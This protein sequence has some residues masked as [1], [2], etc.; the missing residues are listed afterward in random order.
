MLSPVKFIKKKENK[1]NLKQIINATTSGSSANNKWNLLNKKFPYLYP[2]IEDPNFALKISE[3]KE[4]NDTKYD[5]Q[6]YDVTKE[7]QKICNKKFELSAHQQF[8]KNFLSIET[9]YNSLLLYHG[10]GSG[11]TCTA[12]GVAEE[13]RN[14]MKQIGTLKKII[15]VASPNVQENFKLQLFDPSKLELIDGIWNIKNCVGDIFLNE[16]NPM[17][18]KNISK[19]KIVNDI[20]KIINNYYLFYGY[21]EFANT[22]IKDSN[23]DSNITNN[24]EK[25]LKKKL[26][27]IYSGRLIIIDEVHNIRISDDNKDKRVA[28]QLF[29][30]VS[31]VDSL[32][33]LLLSATPL[34][35]TYKEI[36]WLMNIMNI[37]DK[38]SI[39][40]I[41]DVF[42]K[43]GNLKVD[44]NGK[45]IGKEL[46]QEKLTGYVSYVRGDNPYSF[47]Y[48][49]WPYEFDNSKNINLNNYPTMQ[50]NGKMIKKGI[51]HLSLYMSNI[52]EYQQ[53]G[54]NLLLNKIKMNENFE[55]ELEKVDET[56]TLGY[57]QLQKPIEALNIVYPN[58]VIDNLIAYGEERD[59][60]ENNEFVGKSGLNNIMKFR[61]TF[62]PPSKTDFEYKDLDSYGRI[63]S[64]ENIGKYSSKIENICKNIINSDGIILIYSQYLDGGL[65]PVALALEEMGFTR[66]GETPSLFKVKP[67]ENLDLV[68]YTNT[69]G[70]KSIP[71]KYTMIVGDVRLTL[72][73]YKKSDMQALTSNKNK[74]GEIIKVVLI[75]QSGSEGIDFKNIRQVHVLEPWYNLSRIE[76]IIGR[77]VRNCSHKELEFIKRNVQIFLH[78]TELEDENE[79][80]ADLYIYRNAEIK[81]IK[82]GIVNRLLKEI[83]IDCILNK[84]QLNFTK[85][86][87]NQTVK[88]ILSNRKEINYSVGDKPYTPQCDYMD[89]CLYKCKPNDY[90]NEINKLSYGKTFIENN[91]QAI[92]QRI[93]AIFKERHFYE[94]NELIKSIN[95]SREY[96]I[97]QIYSSLDELLNNDNHL[98]IDKYGRSGKLINIDEYYFFQPIE[99][100]NPNISIYERAVPIPFKN[101]KITYIIKDKELPSIDEKIGNQSKSNKG[102]KIDKIDKEFYAEGKKILDKM[103][104]NFKTAYSEVLLVRG[105]DDWYKYASVIIKQ[106]EK[107]GFAS[108]II[109]DVF[110]SHLIEMHIFKELVN[111]LNYIYNNEL[112]DFQKKILA[113]FDLRLLKVGKLTGLMLQNNN[114]EELVILNK[115]NLWNLA[116]PEDY[117]DLLTKIKENT[118][119]IPKLNNIVGFISYFKDN[120]MIYKVKQLNKKRN[121]GARCDQSGK[122]DTIKLLNSVIGSEKYNPSNTKGINQKQLCVLQEFLLRIYDYENRNDKRWFLDPFESVVIN[123]EKVEI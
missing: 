18:S 15:V 6:I 26:N 81:A 78:G 119:K 10:L 85:E 106:L 123:I 101:D 31:N 42:D 35:N 111:I 58:P 20:Q 49:I 97:L 92:I 40:L 120:Y 45:E 107:D 36:I 112:D 14:Y 22:I 44:D 29:N 46:L 54:Y 21:T 90:I 37:N 16:I 23:I 96:P 110:I 113:Y 93:T 63:F 122:S 102:D 1:I 99:I 39:T 61:E 34:Y 52:S 59:E 82:I 69:P 27:E 57:V 19:E 118:V 94:K 66:Y 13:M 116:K 56:G 86:N 64:R 109:E 3:K 73:S 41:K 75:S 71:A 17:N 38:R 24:R 87:L 83:A 30:L 117:N 25:F 11:K 12:I 5:G 53:A 48:R 28:Q 43:N 67:I 32:R 84:E 79:E 68:T 103:Y 8:I 98:L 77:G 108:N 91:N 114:K 121:K 60:D 51:Q 76:Q 65:I 105:E 70:Y 7:A 4:F 72:K 115:D 104:N 55:D 74:N 50:L 33:L 47:P 62:T 9:P 89:S 80:S 95:I 2:N 88:Q 100:T